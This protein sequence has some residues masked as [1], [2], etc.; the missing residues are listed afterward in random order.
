MAPA[1][2]LLFCFN[3]P[4]HTRQTL[5]ALAACAGAEQ[6][7]LHVFLDGARSA[8]DEPAVQA[9]AALFHDLPFRQVRL[10]AAPRNKGLYRSITEGVTQILKEHESVIVLEDDLVVHPAF[11]Q[12]METGLAL[13]R[14]DARVG[15]IH[16]YAMPTTG[17]PDY[18]FL[19][20][21]DCWGW[22][23]W[24]DR[25]QHFTP[26][27]YE[28]LGRLVRERKLEAYMN[29]QGAQSLLMLCR[30]ALGRNQSWAILWHASLWLRG[31]HTLQP[32][33]SLVTN[34]GFDGSGIHC[35]VS[36][37]FQAGLV[38]SYVPPTLMVP[39]EEERYARRARYFMDG[40]DG[41]VLAVLK[42]Q[43]LRFVIKMNAI[44]VHLMGPAPAAD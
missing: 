17:L 1:P 42:N 28:L 3:R 27:P 11:L 39:V 38:D 12:Y 20:G 44:R 32:G 24:R 8:A 15:C 40:C 14:D 16:G 37:K 35:D 10:H 9:V 26:R 30:R 2:I 31:A 36:D 41:S 33:R 6:H 19:R 29:T 22:A 5:A 43:L 21:G 7:E 13:Y 4:D 18:Y 25:W 23:T 34:I